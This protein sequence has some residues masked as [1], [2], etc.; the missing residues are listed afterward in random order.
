VFLLGDNFHPNGV[1]SVDDKQWGKKFERLYDGVHLRG[2]PFFAVVGN[3]D[4]L[5]NEMAEVAYGREHKG[6]ARWHM[7]GLYF[8]RDFGRVNERVLVR[9]VFLDTVRMIKAP[10]EQ[11]D[12]AA[13]AF[14][15]PGDPIW[16]VIVGH[17]PLR[18][19]T[20]ES[21]QQRRAMT[22]LMPRFQAM[23]VDLD[24]S[25][26]DYFQQILDRPG[27]PLHVSANGGSDVQTRDAK[28][29]NPE[30]DVVLTHSGFAVLSFD[31]GKLTVELRDASGK[32][33]A[34]RVRKR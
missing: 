12:F 27:E 11:L 22:G 16:R 32:V 8:A 7:D 3:H 4:H 34:T 31:D 5:G 1:E 28:P 25:A 15:K 24:L 18:T 10:E 30:Q 9:A 33:V 13:R 23:N 21:Y 14:E 17:Y 6:S 26:N 29:E 19:V 20:H 2:T